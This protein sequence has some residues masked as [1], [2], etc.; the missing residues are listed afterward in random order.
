MDGSRRGILDEGG[1]LAHGV[2]WWLS[3]SAVVPG[4]G[5][6]L[7]L[8]WARGHAEGECECLLSASHGLMAGVSDTCTARERCIVYVCD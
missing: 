3:G 4:L 5:L 7:G 1:D 8:G 2:S 6:G